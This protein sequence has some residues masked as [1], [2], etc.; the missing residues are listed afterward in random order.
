M[1]FENATYE[2]DLIH[3]CLKIKLS[4]EPIEKMKCI[5]TT[6]YVGL[7]E[8]DNVIYVEIHFIKEI[9]R[10]NTIKAIKRYLK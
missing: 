9:I 6:F 7:D 8:A 3:N 4:S 1:N 2:L 10:D 5:N